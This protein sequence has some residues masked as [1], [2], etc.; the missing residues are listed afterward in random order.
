MITMLMMAVGLNP[1]YASTILS[2]ED[3]S[4]LSC[5]GAKPAVLALVSPHC[6]GYVPTSLAPE[7]PSVLSDLHQTEYLK[8][9]Y[10]EL[11]QKACS[12]DITVTSNRALAVEANTKNQAGS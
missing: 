7:L 10:H 5:T 2:D 1:G 3:N 4:L 11:L 12:I 6:D 8:L 9:G